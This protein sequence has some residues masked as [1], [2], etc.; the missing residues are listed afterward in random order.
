MLRETRT[1]E[2]FLEN[3]D[4]IISLDPDATWRFVT[5]NLSTHLSESMVRYTALCCGIEDDLG[6]KGRRGILQSVSSRREFLTDASHRIHFVYTPK[7]C[8]WLNQIEIWFG[9]LHS[10]PTRRGC[11]RGSPIDVFG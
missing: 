4:N 3:I 1:E 2:D 7:H 6:I 10:T 8:S 11:T 5:D 9:T